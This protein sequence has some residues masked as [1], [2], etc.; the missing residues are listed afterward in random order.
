MKK[1][2]WTK[3]KDYPDYEISNQGKL[4]RVIP[5]FRGRTGIRIPTICKDKNG[6][7]RIMLYPGRKIFFVHRLVMGSFIGK[8]PKGK[9]I[10]HKNGKK[11][12]NRL[13]NLEY[14]TPKENT[15][16]AEK[17]G[18]RN[19]R[20]SNNNLAKLSEKQVLEIRKTYYFRKN[21]QKMLA[22]KYGVCRDTIHQIINRK[23][24]KHI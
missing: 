19:N 7:L 5:D 12:D 15:G 8:V 11:Q 24:W 2:L 3:I 23:I 22:K 16:H 9:Q 14:C 13:I 18:L 6:Y 1:E 17:M 10:N 20:G 4:K 21:T